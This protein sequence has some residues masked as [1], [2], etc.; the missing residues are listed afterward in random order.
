MV[1]AHSIGNECKVC[2]SN[3]VLPGCI[4]VCGCHRYVH[5]ACLL[6][7][8]N[9][10][11]TN[12]N[13]VLFKCS[14]CHKTIEVFYTTEIKYQPHLNKLNIF[15]IILSL[16]LL[17]LSI[18]TA[19]LLKNDHFKLLLNLIMIAMDSGVLMIACVNSFVIK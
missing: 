4:S 7:E 8:L 9:D 10:Q 12:K 13:E 17:S 2:S 3:V 19:V 16:I 14:R 5:E 6:K 18:Y 1:F 11:N 15:L